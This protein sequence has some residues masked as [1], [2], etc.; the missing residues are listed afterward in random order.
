MTG[1]LVGTNGTAGIG[2]NNGGPS[3][4]AEQEAIL[5]AG[6]DAIADVIKHKN[7]FVARRTFEFWK[8]VARALQLLR[9][10]VKADRHFRFGQLRERYGF[11]NL[12]KDRVSRLLKVIDNESAVE[13]WRASLTAEQRRDWSS[14]EAIVKYCPDIPRK[15]RP[16]GAIRKRV[17]LR[18]VLADAMKKIEGL[19]AH[20]AEL[21]AALELA[22]SEAVEKS[23]AVIDPRG[24]ITERSA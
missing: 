21:E 13:A 24:E 4:S 14:A 11:G 9:D 22:R 7:A 19:E 8:P 20:V 15:S 23:P 6:S 3:L 2:H 18:E 10:V 17:T 1:K 5:R 16:E 12:K